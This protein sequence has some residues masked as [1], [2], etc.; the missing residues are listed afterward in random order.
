MPH[1]IDFFDAAYPRAV[2]DGASSWIALDENNEVVG[3][4]AIFLHRFTC[5]GV[6]YTGTLGTNLVFD[7]RH[8]NLT[9]AMTLVERVLADL[10]SHPDVDFTF[11]DPNE[12]ARAILTSLGGF[13]NVSTVWRFVLPVSG[14]G[15]L[16][17][18]VTLYQAVALRGSRR[19]PMAMER[20]SAR[21]FDTRDV[22]QPPDH[23]AALRA[24]HP[25]ELYPRRLK[26]YPGEGDAWYVFTRDAMRVAAV[27]VRTFRGAA[28]AQICSVWRRPGI[29][30]AP[31]L[32]P[33][34]TDL[35]AA[36]V[37]RLQAS[38]LRSS[39]LARELRA[40][41]FLPREEGARFIARACSARGRSL[42][43]SSPDWEITDLDCDAGVDQ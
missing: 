32:R 40:A 21:D 43:E 9:S 31:L 1:L 39:R 34:V 41:G 28:R 37:E 38:S 24:V 12:E 6:Q 26:G 30:L 20:R 33:I 29:S 14:R 27:L 4:V 42:L 25:P 35:R 7:R 22:E 2:E 11:G 5:S 19:E 15:I 18:A 3:H 36:G 8:R 17:P 13:T 16:G 10:E 23:S